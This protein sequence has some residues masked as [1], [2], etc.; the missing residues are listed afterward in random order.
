[1]DL[2]FFYTLF[3]LSG[4]VI[5]P[6]IYTIHYDPNLWGP[7]DPNVFLPERHSTQRHPMAW[8]P[9]GVGPR[10]CVG[11]RFALMEVKTCLI[12]LLRHYTIWPG[13]KI[14]DGFKL[15]EI[16]VIQPDAI[17]VKLEKRSKTNNSQD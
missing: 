2:F 6:D 13:D 14:E 4:S 16:N 12:R 7:E 11:M 10:N 17:F 15:H 1:M 3:R 5:R 9:F 8:M